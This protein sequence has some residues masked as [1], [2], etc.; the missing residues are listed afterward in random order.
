MTSIITA[1]EPG[2]WISERDFAA[3]MRPLLTPPPWVAESEARAK[4]MVGDWHDL[5][6]GKIREVHASPYFASQVELFATTTINVAQVIA[7]NVAVVYKMGARRMVD[8]EPTS[9]ALRKFYAEAGADARA[10]AWNRLAFAA[11]PVL[12]VPRVTAHGTGRMDTFTPDRYIA[13]HDPEDPMMAPASARRSSCAPACPSHA[14]RTR[15]TRRRSSRRQRC[16][17]ATSSRVST[18]AASSR[19]GRRRRS[20][21]TWNGCPRSRRSSPASGRWSWRPRGGRMSRWMSTTSTCRPMRTSGTSARS[22]SGPS[23]RWGSLSPP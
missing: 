5:L 17:W 6:V 18:C 13:L 9:D 3:L 22:S 19:T 2:E 12:V 10:P 16:S 21:A 7:T 1:A 14:T 11:G 4:I 23:S 20:L 15:C 8:S